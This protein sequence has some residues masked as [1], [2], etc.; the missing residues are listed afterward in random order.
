MSV[1]EHSIAIIQQAVT[2]LALLD[3]LEAE[4]TA[5]TTLLARAREWVAWLSPWR[6]L[7]HKS[8]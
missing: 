2:L 8:E 7:E 3:Y 1:R 4:R 5:P 6:W